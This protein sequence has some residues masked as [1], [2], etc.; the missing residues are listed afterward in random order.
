MAHLR[1]S[2]GSGN[3]S[4]TKDQFKSLSKRKCCSS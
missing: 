3:L 4:Q 2:V 1:A